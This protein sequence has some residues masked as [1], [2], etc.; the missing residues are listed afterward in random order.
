MI[1]RTRRGLSVHLFRM[2][3]IARLVLTGACRDGV[4]GAAELL[5]L[6]GFR[7]VFPRTEHDARCVFILK[8]GEGMT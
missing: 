6:L 8:L 1:N 4:K 2:A 3:V 5:H 7:I